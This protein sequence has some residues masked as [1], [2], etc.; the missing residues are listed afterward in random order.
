MIQRFNV[1]N[2]KKYPELLDFIKNNNDSDFYLTH[3]NAR[4]YVKDFDSLKKLLKTSQ[5]VYELKENGDYSAFCLVWKSCGGEKTRYYLKLLSK[6]VNAASDLLRGFLWNVHLELF[7]K[8]S[9]NHPLLN[10]FRKYGF[11]FI[12]GRGHQILL[13]RDKV[14]KAKKR[15]LIEIKEKENVNNTQ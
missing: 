15:T 4:I 2:Q 5:D 3:N 9:K 13:K 6:N 10:V 12:G 11:K 14:V 7:I 8:I 1:R